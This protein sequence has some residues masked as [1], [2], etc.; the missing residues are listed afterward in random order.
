MKGLNTATID[1]IP[2]HELDRLL[3]HSIKGWNSAPPPPGPNADDRD[4][5]DPDG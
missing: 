1:K 4:R 3:W 5:A 2:Q